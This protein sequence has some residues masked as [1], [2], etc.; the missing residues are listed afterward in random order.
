MYT[1]PFLDVVLYKSQIKLVYNTVLIFC[2]FTDFCFCLSTIN[3]CRVRGVKIC[4]GC[5]S[6]LSPFNY[7]NFFLYFKAIMKC[8]LFIADCALCLQVHFI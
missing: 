1:L 8:P 7:L 2:F 4:C 3:S 5:G 6:Y